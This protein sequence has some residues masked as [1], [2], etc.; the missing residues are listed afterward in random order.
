MTMA[1]AHAG[2]PSPRIIASCGGI[3]ASG[4]TAPLA[5][6]ASVRSTSHFE[7]NAATSRLNAAVRTNTCASPVQP[8]RSSRC[9]QSVGIVHE[10]TAL[11]PLDVALQLVQQRMVTLEL[12]DHLQRGGEHDSGYV[13]DGRFVEVSAD[14]DELKAMKREARLERFAARI[15]GTR[16][17]VRRRG[18]AK[19]RRIQVAAVVETLG[20]TDLDQRAPRRA[21]LDTN[22]A[23]DVLTEVVDE[24]PQ[25]EVTR[26]AARIRSRL[27]AIDDSD[28]R[29]GIPDRARRRGATA[30]RLPATIRWRRSRAQ[31]M[32]RDSV[33]RR[34][35]RRTSGPSTGSATAATS[36]DRPSRPAT[37]IRRQATISS[38]ANNN[39]RSPYCWRSD[40]PSVPQYQPSPSSTP[41][42]V[43]APL[44]QS[45]DV[46]RLIANALAEVGPARRE[47]D[48]DARARR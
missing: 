43:L 16:V 7:K 20:V 18:L 15:S 36:T 30:T 5:D 45:R 11:T 38:C 28:R 42:D 40:S 22:A 33:A 17:Q 19:V 41:D 47:F 32:H 26:T 34:R 25:T 27:D 8:S 9:G 6:C 1:S 31:S 12:A 13:F 29:A 4:G 39:G 10:V 48:V 23:D 46:E 21:H 24:T 14:L 44:Q 3:G 2:P 37:A 35:F